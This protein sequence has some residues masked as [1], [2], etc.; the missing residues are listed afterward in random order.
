MS[1]YEEHELKKIYVNSQ[2]DRFYDGRRVL[3]KEMIREL[4]ISDRDIILGLKLD[5]LDRAFSKYRVAREKTC[6]ENPKQYFK[7]CILSA[8]KE[9]WLDDD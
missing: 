1:V 5:H 6:I 7:A 8:I 4:Y 9:I 2:V 3:L